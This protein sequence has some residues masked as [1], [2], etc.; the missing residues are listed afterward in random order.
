MTSLLLKVE[1]MT[2]QNCVKHVT[3]ALQAISGVEQV[4]VDLNKG[5]A[6]IK[7]TLSNDS[8]PF[9]EALAEEGYTAKVI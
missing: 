2:C 6:L 9:L 5:E 4:D 3:H 1:G 8:S 7:G